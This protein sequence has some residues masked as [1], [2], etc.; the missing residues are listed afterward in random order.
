MATSKVIDFNILLYVRFIDDVFLIQVQQDNNFDD[1]IKEFNSFG[2]DGKRLE[3]ESELGPS[4]EVVFLDLRLKIVDGTVIA[5]TYKKPLNLH[6]YIPHFSAHAPGVPRGM[7]YGMLRRF[8]RQN[9]RQEDY[10]KCAENFF[11][12]MKAR[13]Y[14]ADYLKQEFIESASKLDDPTHVSRS[15]EKTDKLVFLHS[16]FHPDQIS[17][18]EIQ[19]CF[20]RTCAS[21]LRNTFGKDD[22]DGKLKITG[23]VVALGRAPNLRDRLCRTRLELP[24]GNRASDHVNNAS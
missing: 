23:L 14:N 10:I 15:T 8:W 13:G 1:L 9:T 24:D 7:I 20:R 6:L 11:L 22:T 3:W 18:R 16:K 2:P 5:S 17:G 4:K 21:A 19:S 12:H